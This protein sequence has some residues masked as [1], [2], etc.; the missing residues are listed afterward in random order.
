M[1]NAV[2]IYKQYNIDFFTLLLQVKVLLQLQ[3]YVI[4]QFGYNNKYWYNQCFKLKF[5]KYYFQLMS[6]HLRKIHKLTCN[7]VGTIFKQYL[8]PTQRNPPLSP[9]PKSLKLHCS[10]P[11]KSRKLHC[12]VINNIK[13]VYFRKRTKKSALII[14]TLIIQLQCSLKNNIVVPR[15][16]IRTRSQFYN[17]NFLPQ[18]LY[19]H[20]KSKILIQ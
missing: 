7:L 18:V 9:S 8:S 3:I 2:L 13:C 5:L 20:K 4:Y 6:L 16:Q 17:I 11:P 14:Y 1:T 15:Q 12:Q 10:P 19:I